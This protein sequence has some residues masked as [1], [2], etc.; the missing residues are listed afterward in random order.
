[1]L[2]GF[3]DKSAQAVATL[4]Y[5]EKPGQQ[6]L[7]FQGRADGEIVRPRG[8]TKFGW[9]CAFECKSTGLTYAETEEAGELKISHLRSAIEDLVE[10]LSR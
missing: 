5:C 1:M 7:I 2:E 10:Y 8:T 9:H 3:S 4:A 6:P